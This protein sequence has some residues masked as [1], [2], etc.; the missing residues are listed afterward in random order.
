MFV[1]DI[2]TKYKIPPNLIRHQLEVAVVGRAVC[3]G[4]TGRPVDKDL[5]TKTLLLHDMGNIIKFK[6]PFMGELEKNAAHWESVQEKF[7]AM[8]GPDVHEATIAIIQE[9]GLPAVAKLIE[10]M[11]A[12][13]HEPEIEVSLEARICE[14]ADCCV[15]PQGITTFDERIED[16]KNRYSYTE[17]SPAIRAA[18]RNGKIVTQHMRN[19]DIPN[20]SEFNFS[21]EITDLKSYVL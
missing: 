17:E 1:S 11:R 8:Y 15:T 18:R 4:W 16:L 9:L 21:K 14:Y 5:I 2:Y 7:R 13:W 6:R 3:Q 19:K 20:M 10:E 12:A